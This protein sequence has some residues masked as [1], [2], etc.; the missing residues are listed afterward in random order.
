M[1]ISF[2]QESGAAALWDG[3][4]VDDQGRDALATGLHVH[5]AARIGRFEEGFL[6]RQVFTADL[7]MQD[8]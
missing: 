3:I 1:T 2:S 5:G 6:V 7:V 8:L 4:E